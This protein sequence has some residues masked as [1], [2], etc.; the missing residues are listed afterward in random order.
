MQAQGASLGVAS[1][2]C[3]LA[4]V[5]WQVLGPCSMLQLEAVVQGVLLRLADGVWW[6]RKRHT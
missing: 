1:G 5:V 6:T 3:Q 4:I 2:V